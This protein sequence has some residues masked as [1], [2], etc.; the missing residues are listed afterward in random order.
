MTDFTILAFNGGY[1]T[2]ISATLDILSAASRIAPALAAPAPTWRIVSTSG[3]IVELES[4][5][6]VK[7][8]R[9]P[10]RQRRDASVWIIPGLALN[11]EAD[12]LASAEREDMQAAARSIANHLDQGGRAAAC[13]SAVFLLQQAQALDHRRVTT[14]WW[15]AP[16]LQRLNPTAKVDAQRMVCTDGPITTAGAAFAQTDLMLHLLRGQCGSRAADAVARMLLID[17]REAQGK[18]IVPEVLA[19]GDELISRLVSRIEHSLP[20]PPGIVALAREFCV[21]ERTL[22]RRVRLATG[23]ST[24]ALIQSVKL[25]KARALLEQSRFTVEQISEAVGYS[26]STA[27]RRLMKKA[28]GA[29]P[30]HYRARGA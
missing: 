16:L 29:S 8:Q 26:D 12:V 15:L 5:L 13:C 6:L 9:L 7:T 10:I 3:G 25:R 1:G 14:T 4:G 24:L 11:T 27:L 18:Y 28:T 20:E 21:S 2:G 30:S 17:G 22:A 19:N 23:K